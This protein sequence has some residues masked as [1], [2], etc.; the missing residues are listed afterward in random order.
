MN[1]RHALTHRP[2]TR[3]QHNAGDSRSSTT[4]GVQLR[5]VMLTILISLPL[6]SRLACC[7]RLG[8][9][10]LVDVS[11]D[12]AARPRVPRNGVAVT[13]HLYQLLL[14][15]LCGL[16]SILSPGNTTCTH[17]G[18]VYNGADVSSERPRAV[19]YHSSSM[20]D[21]SSLLFVFTLSSSATWRRKLS[22]R[23]QRH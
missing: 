23:T 12:E 15:G 1:V 22:R 19:S 5:V 4:L 17:S 3:S 13:G 9:Y 2:H 16:T 18:T 11:Q 20:N 21:L 10:A 7:T 8:R 6:L 14:P